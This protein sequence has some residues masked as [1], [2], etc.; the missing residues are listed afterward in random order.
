MGGS[1]GPYAGPISPPVCTG[2]NAR[3]AR[4]VPIES[5]V[6]PLVRVPCTEARQRKTR[7]Q[8]DRQTDTNRHKQTQTDTNRHKQTQTD[9]N[10]HKQ[11]QTDTN[12]HKQTQTDTN[13]HKQTQTDRQ[14]NRDHGYR[15]IA[16]IASAVALWLLHCL[17]RSHKKASTGTL[18]RRTMS[19][20]FHLRR[21]CRLFHYLHQPDQ[22]ER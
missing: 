5:N 3:S 13:R 12:R 21:V 9:T 8:T 10:R 1:I 20:F 14:T 6:L 19:G 7:R 11:T 16:I 4:P 22:T 15:G 17:K 2:Y 18:M